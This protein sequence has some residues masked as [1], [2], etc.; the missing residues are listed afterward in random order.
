MQSVVI[1]MTPVES[2]QIHSIGHDAGTNTL[3][4]RFKS[5]KGTTTTLYHYSNVTPE[6]FAAFRDAASI[7]KHF[8]AFIKNQSSKY[9]YKKISEAE[10]A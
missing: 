10:A 5:F 8:A 1:A 4:I 3:A 7:G 9:P 6:D 2:S